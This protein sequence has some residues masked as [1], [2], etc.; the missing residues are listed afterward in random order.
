MNESRLTKE[1][2]KLHNEE[3]LV[4]RERR[5]DIVD[6]LKRLILMSEGRKL[7]LKIVKG[8]QW[9]LGLPDEYLKDP[10]EYLDSS[11]SL[12]DMGD[13]LR[14]LSVDS[15]EK[16]LSTLQRNVVKRGVCLDDLLMPLVFLLYPSKGLRLKVKISNWLD[17]FQKL[18]YVSPYEDCLNLN[19]SCDVFEKRVLGVLHELL[20]LFVD[21]SAERKKILC[22]RTYLD[23]PQK[24]YKAF[25]RHPH[26]FYLSLRNKT[27]TTILKEAY[28]HDSAIEAHPVLNEREKYI[29][30]M[31]KSDA[32][33]LRTRQEKNSCR[34][35]L[36]KLNTMR[37]GYGVFEK[38]KSHLCRCDL[39]TEDI[40]V[41]ELPPISG[42]WRSG[43]I[44]VSSGAPCFFETNRTQFRIWILSDK[45]G[46]SLK[47]FIDDEI[48]RKE[49]PGIL[50][51]GDLFRALAFHPQNDEF[52]MGIIG[53]VKVDA[54]KDEFLTI[55]ELLNP[56]N[57]P[58]LFVAFISS[59]LTPSSATVLMSKLEL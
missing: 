39:E 46:W 52:A 12:V 59:I 18:P 29:R 33:L 53:G 10:E 34:F 57:F 42:Y 35:E 31:K 2:V 22:L 49:F 3:E 13:G 30:L 11:F 15:C 16:V 44:G 23:L 51:C 28:D 58:F 25:D 47:H 14:G 40:H 56:S 36:G 50:K 9:Y 8:M 21:H 48:L 26:I 19:R 5:E 54:G 17:E 37:Y 32:L 55:G 45:V 27:C 1:V 4:Y 6:G 38:A 24:F 7:P 20:G 43:C 41:M